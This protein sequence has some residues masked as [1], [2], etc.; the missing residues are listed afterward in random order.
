MSRYLQVTTTTET[1]EEARS[2]AYVLVTE[3]LAA[4]AQVLAG[5][6]T[7]IYHWHGKL[8][9]SSEFMCLFKTTAELYP[10]L[11]TRIRELHSYDVPEIIAVEITAGSDGYLRWIDD[12]TTMR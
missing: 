11:E 4:C 12:S 3:K 7:S 9:Q 8:E 2:I 1:E 6:I 5:P 10:L